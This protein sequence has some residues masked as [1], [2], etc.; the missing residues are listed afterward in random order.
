MFA[1]VIIRIG[2]IL[3]VCISQV[4]ILCNF[5]YKKYSLQL[6]SLFKLVLLEWQITD[7]TLKL[8]IIIQVYASEYFEPGIHGITKTGHS[9]STKSLPDQEDLLSYWIV[10]H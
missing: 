4:T 6:D 5:S 2:L 1:C 7:G 10:S 9:L 3:I 8:F